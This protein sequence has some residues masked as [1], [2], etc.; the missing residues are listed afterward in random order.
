ML[1]HFHD[2]KTEQKYQKNESQSWGG[3][4]DSKNPSANKSGWKGEKCITIHFNYL[5]IDF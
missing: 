2:S 4:G 5:S 1:E 3:P